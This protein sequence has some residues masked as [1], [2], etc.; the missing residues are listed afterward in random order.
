MKKKI[1]GGQYVIIKS[2]KARLQIIKVYKGYY[3]L[4]CKK[5]NYINIQSY[6]LH[7][8]KYLIQLSTILK[9]LQIKT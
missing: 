2:S 8:Q 3:T 5:K 7:Q 1:F 9:V 6:M 4:Q